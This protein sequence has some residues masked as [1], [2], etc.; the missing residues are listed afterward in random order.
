[1]RV[2][3][4][5][6]LCNDP[7]QLGRNKPQLP[8]GPHGW[9]LINPSPRRQSHVK[10]VSAACEARAL[11]PARHARG[12]TAKSHHTRRPGYGR[13]PGRAI[14]TET[15]RTSRTEVC[16][17]VPVCLAHESGTRGS[18]GRGQST[19]VRGA[20]TMC[21]HSDSLRQG[22]NVNLPSNPNNPSPYTFSLSTHTHTHTQDTHTCRGSR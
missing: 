16:A 15:A 19:R 14:S 20:I 4:Q 22:S 12:T 21:T 3:V 8:S 18:G 13:T 1:M 7:R 5:L 6:L 9:P 10:L 17:S 2:H 11:S